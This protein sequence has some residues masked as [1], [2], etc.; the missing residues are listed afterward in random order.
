MCEVGGEF[1]KADKDMDFE[2]VDVFS[3]V[4]IICVNEEFGYKETSADK[5][6]WAEDVEKFHSWKFDFIISELCL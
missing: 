6:T 1:K 2:S 5:A 4:W 3:P